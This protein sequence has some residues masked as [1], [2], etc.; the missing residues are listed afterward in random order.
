MA[1]V[2]NG[3]VYVNGDPIGSVDKYKDGTVIDINYDRPNV[4]V[5]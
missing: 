3:V 1:V 2:Q 4:I 5:L